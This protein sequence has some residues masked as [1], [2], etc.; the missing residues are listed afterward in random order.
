[1][2]QKFQFMIFTL[3]NDHFTVWPSSVT[4]TFKLPEQMFQMN[5][6]TKLFWKPYINVEVMAWTSSVYDHIITWPS[7]V[8]STFNLHA[9]VSN[10]TSTPQGQ[11]LW[12]IILKSMN[13][14]RSHGPDKL[15]LWPFY[16][17][18]FKC[19][20]DLQ[21]TWINDS[22]GTYTQQGEHLCQIILK[23]KTKCRS[24]GLD[25]LNLRPFYHLTFKCDL[26]L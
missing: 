24:Y 22:N 18:A 12:H 16:H 23:S 2:K 3:A 5:N 17:L 21:V 10:G 8:T 11:Q 1:M 15:N 6:C 25:K 4:L 14:C 26:D 20:L 13:K 7:S 9:Q 19:D